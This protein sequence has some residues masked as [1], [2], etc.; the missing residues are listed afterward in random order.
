LACALEY[1]SGRTRFRPIGAARASSAATACRRMPDF[2]LCPRN[3]LRRAAKSCL[4]V[5]FFLSAVFS[6]A[7]L[8]AEE[9]SL[10]DDLGRTVSLPAPAKRIV[11][12]YAGH[13]ENILVL[14]GGGR[15]VGIAE[16]DDPALFPGAVPLPVRSDA[17][18]IL[19]LAPDLVITRPLVESV[20]G[21]VLR[22]IERSGIPVFSLSPP[23]PGTM[24]H[25]LS[26]LGLLLG[27]EDAGRLWK[28]LLVALHADAEIPRGTISRPRVFLETTGKGLRTC[29][30]SSWAAF[31][32][33]VAGGV[34]AADS[35][36]PSR[37]ESPLAPWGEERLLD[38]A[39]N[40]LDVYLVQVGPMNPVDRGDV[41]SRPWISGLTGAKIALVPEEMISRPSLLRMG[42]AVGMLRSLFR[43]RESEEEGDRTVSMRNIEF[44]GGKD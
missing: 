8:S 32:I 12:L 35:A 30:P 17:E 6:P 31:L 39:A 19:A 33:A 41:L 28:E 18:R 27:V 3:P 20:N 43:Q 25:Y 40:G 44:T 15:L 10:A 1:Q 2:L 42:D 38:L 23:L 34:N 36:V 37:P 29:S 13:S 16:G 7:L 22:A 4:L 14:G 11:S 24:E 9:I 26:R 5:F 21:G